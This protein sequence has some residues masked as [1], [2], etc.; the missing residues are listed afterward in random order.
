MMMKNGR[1]GGCTEAA[2]DLQHAKVAPPVYALGVKSVVSQIAVA[3]H[4]STSQGMQK[5]KSNDN[6]F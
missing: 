1:V 3:R 5:L 2:P 6:G 4:A